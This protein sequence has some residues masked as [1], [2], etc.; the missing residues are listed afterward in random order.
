MMIP[1]IAKI[2]WS[3]KGLAV[4][5]LKLSIAK[6]EWAA[7]RCNT[8]EDYLDLAFSPSRVFPLPWISISPSQVK[9][10]I[11]EL[12]RILARRQPRII[13][14]VGT[15]RGGTLFLFAKISSP[16]A[17]IIGIDL[18]GGRFGGGYP[19]WRVSLYES[20]AMQNQKISLIRE[21]SHDL[22]TLKM[23]EKIL[24][25]RK[26]DFLFIDG[27][28][29]YDGVKSDFQMYGSLVDEGGVIAFHDIVPGSCDVV[30]GVPRFWNEI[31]H[32]FEF[33]ELVRN[34]KQGG[35]GIGVIYR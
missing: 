33:I 16:D 23:V 7:N 1:E 10:E 31:K 2:L 5:S 35:F 9:E 29:T 25:N 6:V 24:G 30:G 15:A 26:L 22:C 18:P 27:D 11:A 4:I 28:H 13:L 20:F 19:E 14:E 21:D 8:L 17:V 3:E 12:V 34:W 32:R